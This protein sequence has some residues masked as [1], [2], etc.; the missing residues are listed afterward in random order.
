MKLNATVNGYD[1]ILE[2]NI[3]KCNNADLSI[4]TLNQII[5]VYIAFT[6]FFI[7]DDNNAILNTDDYG[8]ELFDMIVRFSELKAIYK[9]LRDKPKVHHLKANNIEL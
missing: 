3:L 4:E 6:E 8:N 7:V 5:G 2:N 9:E 1:V